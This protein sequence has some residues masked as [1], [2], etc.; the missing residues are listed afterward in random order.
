MNNEQEQLL[1][2][3]TTWTMGNGH[4]LVMDRICTRNTNQIKFGRKKN[5]SV[6]PN[7]PSMAKN[8]ENQMLST[9]I[10]HH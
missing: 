4:L 10:I 6:T 5:K 9:Q 3:C 1:T 7:F 8:E 2:M